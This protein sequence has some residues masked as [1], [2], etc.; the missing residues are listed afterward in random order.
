MIKKSLYII[1]VLLSTA[2]IKAMQHDNS[3]QLISQDSDLSVSVSSEQ[4]LDK[5]NNI[6]NVL[7]DQIEK[8]TFPNINKNIT[9]MDSNILS[10]F[11]NVIDKL[12]L[13]KTTP[14]ILFNISKM[15]KVNEFSL[16]CLSK[17]LDKLPSDK[18]TKEILFNISKMN[19]SELD[20]LSDILEKQLPSAQITSDILINISKMDEYTLC[21]LYRVLDL[22]KIY[23]CNITTKILL[24]ISKM[25]KDALKNLYEVLGK[26][27]Y[28]YV[29]DDLSDSDELDKLQL[30]DNIP[31]EILLL[32][33]SKMDSNTLHILSKIFDKL[34]E[35]AITKKMSIDISK[36]YYS[37]DMLCMISDD[38]PCI[39]TLHDLSDVI[40]KLQ[41][42][43]KIPPKIISNI[44]SIM[45]KMNKPTLLYLS[46]VIDKLP[47]EKT[48]PE[49]LLNI[50]KMDKYTLSDLY[51]VLC[52]LP[53]EKT[54]PD[55]LFNISKMDEHALSD[56]YTIL[57]RLP[58]EKTTTD[59][60]LNI[61]K[62]DSNTLF[63]LFNVL[64]KLPLDKI[65]TKTLLNI[66]KIDKARRMEMLNINLW[67]K[68]TDVEKM[69]VLRE[70]GVLS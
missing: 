67:D 56:L 58:L 11:Y 47:L 8:E 22:L 12:P 33:L 27:P 28:G 32:N 24:N 40:D 23:E 39:P 45:S 55:I 31:P 57:Y 15:S 9:E 50:S 60:L 51:I 35:E 38:I 53:L 16:S 17:V 29:L 6:H 70:F 63:H 54:T 64:D 14:D 25:N 66:S 62:M 10:D 34:P 30:D 48:T 20:N 69:G 65:T 26:L 13:E 19:K 52:R 46:D 49:T 42:L 59:I 4:I 43:D 36:L 21:V 68:K 1:V 41:P 3:Y 18:V 5:I 44:I 7:I 37:F 61:S 2:Q